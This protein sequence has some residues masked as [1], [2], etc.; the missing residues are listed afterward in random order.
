MYF[1]DWLS[2]TEKDLKDIYL[3]EQL[4]RTV[5]TEIDIR[6]RQQ[7]FI[8]EDLIHKKSTDR[9]SPTISSG[10]LA[11]GIDL[12]GSDIDIMCVIKSL[13]VVQDERNIKHPVQRKTLLMET[14]TDHPGFC[15]LRLI[16]GGDGTNNSMTYEY[17]ESKG[18]YLSVNEL[19]C[20][21]NKMV[22]EYK[23]SPHGPC[24]S[25][26]FQIYDFAFCLRCKYL[27]YNAM[28]WA[29]RY[30]QQWPPNSVI[31]KIKKHGCLFV[32]IGPRTMPDCNILWRLS[33]SVAEKLLVHSFNFIQ[34]VCYCLLK[35]TLKHIVNTNKL[36]EGLLCS[37]FLKTALFW[38]SEEIDIDTFQL[39][40][41]FFCFSK[42]LDKLLLWVKKCYCPNYFIPEN[43]MFLGKVNSDNNTIL[44]N[45]LDGIKCDGID[46][47]TNQLFPYSS[48]SLRVQRTKSESAFIKLDV[49][50][51]RILRFD[52][53]ADISKCLKALMFTESLIKS[54]CST[55]IV[56]VCKHHHAELSQYVAQLLPPPSIMTTPYIIQKRY[57]RHL[58][59]GTKTDAVSG[60]LLYASFYY[61]TG[62]YKVTLRLTDYVLSRCSSDMLMLDFIHY[63]EEYMDIMNNYRKNVYSTMTLNERMRKATVANVHYFQNSSLI[64]M[65]LQLEVNDDDIF[66]PPTVMSHYLRFMCYHHF[67]D[68][69]NRQQALHDLNLSLDGT[70]FVSTNT[71]SNSLTILGVCYEIFGDKDA[72]YQCYDE[73]LQCDGLICLSAQVRKS[74]LLEI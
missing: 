51:Y 4:V 11:E 47:L 19:V 26:Q 62:Q 27:P 48:R 54:Q 69:F 25:D 67:G 15:R 5:G 28:P 55:F 14:D 46:S 45:I 16:A 73:A 29:W 74:K 32:P 10:S 20:N 6:K 64:P 33:F 71:L 1:I 30:R 35:L 41:L 57:H 63:S 68:I 13:D 34:L 52:F 72:A 23:L 56:G 38:V 22:P 40:K 49:L 18:F 65:E 7:L 43:N 58:K 53:M 2:W 42:C 66:I 59:D 24:L 21:I 17:V 70:H 8:I 31:D 60:W 37:Y 44:L 3:Y 61:V 12:Q 36:A 9:R 50:F 39:S